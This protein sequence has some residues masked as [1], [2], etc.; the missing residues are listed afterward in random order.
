[1]RTRKEDNYIYKFLTPSM[2]VDKE[3]L[4]DFKENTSALKLRIQQ[5]CRLEL[6]CCYKFI[7][8]IK[9]KYI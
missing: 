8:K 3:Y 2:Y 1:M 4:L 7:L 6:N 5:Q 9:C